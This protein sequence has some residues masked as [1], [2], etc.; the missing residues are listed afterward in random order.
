MNHSY[1]YDHSVIHVVQLVSKTKTTQKLTRSIVLFY[2]IKD[3]WLNNKILRQLRSK[4]ILGYW[5]SA[6]LCLKQD[7]DNTSR[8]IKAQRVHSGKQKASFS[9]LIFNIDKPVKEEGKREKELNKLYPKYQES[10]LIFEKLNNF[11]A[12]IKV[13][14]LENDYFSLVINKNKVR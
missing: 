12:Q 11:K 5:V 10:S 6:E 8:K 2:L 1:I 14:E 7:S 3:T 13:E 9:W 4:T